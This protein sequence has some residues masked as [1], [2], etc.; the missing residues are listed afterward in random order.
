M[1]AFKNPRAW[2][3]GLVSGV[4]GGACSSTAAWLGTNVVKAAGI[5]IP[6]LNLKHLGIILLSAGAFNAFSYLAKSPLP[7]L[8]EEP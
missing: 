7:Q 3:Y 8:N 2:A 6:A 4:V 5:D 1:K